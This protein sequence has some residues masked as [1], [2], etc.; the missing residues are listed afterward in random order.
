MPL[1]DK[2]VIETIF[3]NYPKTCI[4]LQQFQLG[5]ALKKQI[6][7]G[8]CKKLADPDPRAKEPSTDPA[9]TAL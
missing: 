2:K 6:R 4:L 7:P 3:G 9:S 8:T 5:V 1:N